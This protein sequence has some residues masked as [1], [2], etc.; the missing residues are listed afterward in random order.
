MP[1]KPRKPGLDETLT[2][3]AGSDHRNGNEET[4]EKEDLLLDCLMRWEA[5]WLR[6]EN[7][8]LGAI[9]QDDASLKKALSRRIVERKR[10]HGLIGRRAF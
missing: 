8:T 9:C 6:G 3:Y 7:P 5:G 10:L 4:V 2:A 1:K